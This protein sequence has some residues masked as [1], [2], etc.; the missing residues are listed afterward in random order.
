[1]W[2][3][4]KTTRPAAGFRACRRFRSATRSV[5]QRLNVPLGDGGV[6][7]CVGLEVTPDRRPLVYP[8]TEAAP[9]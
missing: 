6:G 7:R 4:L 3:G 8:V 2:I 1:M 9:P 5:R